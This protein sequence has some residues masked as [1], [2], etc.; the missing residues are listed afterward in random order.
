MAPNRRIFSFNPSIVNL[1]RS[2]KTRLLFQ[3]Q[4]D[5]SWGNVTMPDIAPYVRVSPFDSSHGD[6]TH[7]GAKVKESYKGHDPW[8]PNIALVVPGCSHLLCN[9][10]KGTSGDICGTCLETESEEK[11][12]IPP[13]RN[14]AIER[15]ADIRRRILAITPY[16]RPLEHGEFSQQYTGKKKAFYE[17]AERKLEN[18]AL[19][20]KDAFTKNF[21][22]TEATKHKWKLVDGVWIDETDPRNISPREGTFNVAVGR[23]IKPAEPLLLGALNKV[24]G[25]K[26]VMKGMNAAQVGGEI[27]AK[28]AR[29]GGN[30]LA[31]ALGID[32]SRFDR[33]VSKIFL[34]FEHGFYTPLVPRGIERKRFAELLSWQ[35]YN[36]GKA[37]CNDGTLT[38]KVEGTRC[39]GDM[40]TGLGN[41][42]IASCMIIAYCEDRKVPF[43][44]VN[45][46]DDCVVIMARKHLKRFQRGFQEYFTEMGFV[47]VTEDPVY[48][49][50]KISFCQSQP[51]YDGHSHVMVRDPHNC[52][53][54]DCFSLKPWTNAKEYESWISA[55]GNSG[56]AL[57]GGIPVLHSFYKSF[58]R[59]GRNAKPLSL[60]DPA[61]IGGLYWASKGMNRSGCAVSDEARFSFWRA[62][63]ITPDEQTCLEKQYDETTPFYSEV[64]HDPEVYPFHEHGLLL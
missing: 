32:A 64:R 4:K 2:I 36:K 27:A 13:M 15:L 34:E 44:L 21:T 51:V 8:S 58:L 41:C 25:H 49:L 10:C 42:L 22:K 16:L 48:E 3:K 50:E 33:S 20:R 53:S 31:V 12:T 23:Y 56:T 62:F 29:F 55:V 59:A 61:L 54:K 57:A 52:I 1:E 45:N 24:M 43:E 47:M 60:K 37:R 35:I 28:W 6:C 26:I 7:C 40:N 14:I 19:S 38:Y 46:G 11:F 18:G 9:D 39:S 30:E 5:G 17:N 63:G